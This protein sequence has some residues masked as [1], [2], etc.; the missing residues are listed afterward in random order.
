MP[1]LPEV[2]TT[3]KSLT[4]LIGRQLSSVWR[5]DKSLRYPIG[6]LA[7]LIGYT[8][9]QVKRRAKY[10]ILS[11]EQGDV[12]CKV[13]IHLGMSGNLTQFDHGTPVRK[14]DHLVLG[15]GARAL[16]YQDAR[17]F[18]M[19][20]MA[21]VYANKLLGHLGIEPLDGD[22][23]GAYLHAL[24][25]SLSPK[26]RGMPIKQF[27]MAQEF[28]VGVGN[29]YATE[30]LFLTKLHPKTPISVLSAKDWEALANAI[31]DILRKS[32]ALG[33]STLKDFYA[34][35]VAGYFAQTLHVYGNKGQPCPLCGTPIDSWTIGGR[36]SAF[37][38]NCQA[39]RASD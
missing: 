18:G 30:A 5:S 36:A 8:L 23:D 33:G 4:P 31:I 11:F 13:L 24:A 1:E 15:F 16:H 19:V 6:D 3:K 17:R 34:D 28:V 9:T 39:P 22:F 27:I 29:I 37:C 20:V 10:L 32:I 35:G 14:H 12:V 7:P 38:P 21:D 25:Q 26:R 2:E